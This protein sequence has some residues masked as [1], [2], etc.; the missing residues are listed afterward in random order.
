M[1]NKLKEER[2]YTLVIA[3]LLIVLF[4]SMSAVFIQ[5][6]LSHAK[7]EQTVDQGNLAVTAAEMGV[8]KYTKEAE[9][10][11]G[12][13]YTIVNTEA[14]KKKVL[15]EAEVKKYP[16]HTLLNANCTKTKYPIMQEW[17]NCN[18]EEYDQ[19]LRMQFLTEMKNQLALSNMAEEQ[20]SDTLSHI[21]G[22]TS[23]QPVLSSNNTIELELEVVGKKMIASQ[24][25]STSL[26]AEKTKSLS[27]KLSFPEVPFFDESA[28]SEVEVKWGKPITDATNFFPQL[29]DKVNDPSVGPC[30]PLANI[31]PEMG[32]C[33]Y[34]DLIGKEDEYLKK[35]AEVK[36]NSSFY[37]I[38]D[39]FPDQYSQANPYKIPLLIN[40]G[41]IN[42][43]T[44]INQTENLI[45]YYKGSLR[46]GEFNPQSRNNF[47]VAEVINFNNNQNSFD[48][49]FISIGSK[50]KTKAVY[51]S[52]KITINNGS[53]L[54]VNLD[55]ITS[56][57]TNIFTT[58]DTSD[59]EGQS[60]SALAVRGSG[61]IHLYSKTATPTVDPT[62]GKLVYFND[63]TK[64]LESCGVAINYNY[65]DVE[66][67]GLPLLISDLEWDLDMEVNY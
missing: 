29:L 50:D 21:L 2:G 1:I 53:K 15:L 14:Q 12:K 44:N 60:G 5:A 8:E 28:L 67:F 18:I 49:T 9:K 40:D 46:L 38:L 51:N 23:L 63:A 57:P 4:L 10:A 24:G 13:S 33:K 32:P 16:A 37:M 3:L 59:S 39:K 26:A 11:F 58:I 45:M 52:K 62:K 35:L 6:S 64:F 66:K 20:V 17:I 48:N 42:K 27:T 65:E 61:K 22:S 47:L 7:Q 56:D 36:V 41:T 25:S 30:P 54:C 34:T 31:T 43:N 19:E 55:G